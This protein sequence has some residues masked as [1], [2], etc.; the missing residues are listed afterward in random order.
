MI[1][2]SG[3]GFEVFMVK[4]EAVV[5]GLCLTSLH[6]VVTQETTT[7]IFSATE[8]STSVFCL[9]T[10]WHHNLE[11]HNLKEL[12]DISSFGQLNNTTVFYSML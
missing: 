8:T 6:G 1:Q 10:T 12:L 11:D 7:S 3:A 2:A 5:F 4:K 9:I